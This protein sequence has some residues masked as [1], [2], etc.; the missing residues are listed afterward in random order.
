MYHHVC[1]IY[2]LL[3]CV[4]VHVPWCVCGTHVL[5]C[6]YACAIVCVIEY[7][8]HECTWCV[9]VP[10]LC[11]HACAIVCVLYM[12]SS[13]VQVCMC[14]GTCVFLSCVS[15]HVSMHVCAGQEQQCRPFTTWVTMLGS[16]RFVH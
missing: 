2:V 13:H 11:E 5:L 15:V 7:F 3:S 12:Y 1:G 10:L 14:H 16:K 4:S 9:C 6:E 8:S